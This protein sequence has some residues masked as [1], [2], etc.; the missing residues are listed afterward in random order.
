MT[1]IRPAAPGGSPGSNERAVVLGPGGVVGT[2]WMIG[3][4]TGP[5]GDGVDQAGVR[6]AAEA[7]KRVRAAWRDSAG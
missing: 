4:A 3:L 1:V 6:Q 7:A 5:R 2:A